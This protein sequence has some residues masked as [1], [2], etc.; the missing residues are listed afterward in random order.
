MCV[1]RCW[2]CE[3]GILLPRLLPVLLQWRDGQEDALQQQDALR[4]AAGETQ[5]RPHC[6]TPVSRQTVNSALLN[7]LGDVLSE[8]KRDDS[9][10]YWKLNATEYLIIRVTQMSVNPPSK[11][12]NRLQ[13]L[14]IIVSRHLNQLFN[15]E[16]LRCVSSSTSRIKL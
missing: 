4:Q 8:R 2:T 3:D 15:V 10:L 11:D 6:P 14:R 1:C 9:S 7:K 12:G 5:L 16:T 13:N